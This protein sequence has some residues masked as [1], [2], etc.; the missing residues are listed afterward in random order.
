ML[1][2]FC[3]KLVYLGGE[4]IGLGVLRLFLVVCKFYLFYMGFCFNSK[5][6]KFLF[7]IIGIWF[8][9]TEELDIVK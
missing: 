2:S 8:L 4:G 9:L 7:L 1:E 3:F 6:I 5:I